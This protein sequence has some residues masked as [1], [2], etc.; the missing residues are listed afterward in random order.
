MRNFRVFF[1]I[2]FCG[3]SVGQ[4]S[5]FIPDIV[6]ARLAAS[7]LFH[8]IE[9]PTLI[10][11]LSEKGVRIVSDACLIVS[12]LVISETGRRCSNEKGRIRLPNTDESRAWR[13]DFERREGENIGPGW[14]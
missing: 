7:L 10:D 11:S 3:Q 12:Y 4:I 1:A 9:Y 8:L 5:S 2:A 6:K 14:F 13:L